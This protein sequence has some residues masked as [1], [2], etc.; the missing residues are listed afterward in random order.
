MPCHYQILVDAEAETPL[1]EILAEHGGHAERNAAQHGPSR[2]PSTTVDTA[3]K[4]RWSYEKKLTK[5]DLRILVRQLVGGLRRLA[6]G[7]G[8]EVVVCVHSFNHVSPPS[9]RHGYPTHQ[10]PSPLLGS[11]Q[12]SPP[13]STPITNKISPT[14]PLLASHH[15]KLQ[16]QISCQ[17]TIIIDSLP[18]LICIP[19]TIPT[20]TNGQACNGL[21]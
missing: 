21:S 20:P 15:S 6:D 2:T 14:F 8:A 1:P 13:H 9:P 19:L 12:L 7:R 10:D 17:S 4:I 16:F 5:A 11:L 18:S 3:S